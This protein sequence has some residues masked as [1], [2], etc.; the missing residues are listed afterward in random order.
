[1]AQE[2]NQWLISRATNKNDDILCRL[3]QLQIYKRQ[4]SLEMQEIKW[5]KSLL[6]YNKLENYIKLGVSALLEDK[7]LFL[8]YKKQISSEDFKNLQTQPISK[9]FLE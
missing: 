3:N 2:L 6:S 9:F 1:M 4:R 7:D 5:L 8:F